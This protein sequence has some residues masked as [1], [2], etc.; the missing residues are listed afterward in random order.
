MVLFRLTTALAAASLLAVASAASAPALTPT[1]SINNPITTP[2]VTV[3][4]NA[5]VEV[6]CYQTPGPSFENHG[7][8]LFQTEGNC[9]LVC[10]ELG[11]N[12][13]AVSD[14]TDCWCGDTLPAKAY[15]ADNSTCDTTC[16]GDNKSKC[17]GPG[18]LWVALT[19]ATRNKV[20]TDPNPSSSSSAAAATPTAAPVVTSTPKASKSSGSNTIAI[21]VGVV[22]GIVGV[23]ALGF[24][25]WFFLRRRRQRQAEE[26]YRRQAANVNSFVNGGKL[27]TSSSSMNDSR[28]DPSFVD[29][30]QSNGSIA[31]NE[32][33]SRRI[34]KVTNA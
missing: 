8:Y 24:G 22:V 12:V 27:H 25:V 3:P 32:D 10:L 18:L 17:G 2:T 33:Y 7:P 21:A 19:G 20:G 1:V 11:K 26:D 6:G 28:L 14:G 29:R 31:D 16:A 4:A 9:Q 15:V 5:L 34:L 23:F 13:Q 30:R